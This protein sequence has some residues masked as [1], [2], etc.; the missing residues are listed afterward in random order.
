[1]IKWQQ[2]PPQRHIHGEMFLARQAMRDGDFNFA[3]GLI[4]PALSEG[5]GLTMDTYADLLFQMGDFPGAFKVWEELGDEDSLDY[6][7]KHVSVQNGREVEILALKSLYNIDPEKYTFLLIDRLRGQ[8]QTDQ[9]IS[10]LRSSIENF[11]DSKEQTN[12]FLT[13]GNIYQEKKLYDDAEVLYL[14]VLDENPENWQAWVGLGSSYFVNDKDYEKA[15]KCFQKAIAIEPTSSLAYQALGNLYASSEKWSDAIKAYQTAAELSPTD[16]SCQVSLAKAY[17]ASN[18][19]ANAINIYEN[20]VLQF[21][22]DA[23]FFYLLSEVYWLDKQPGEAITA[24][25]R[26]IQLDST[27]IS[28]LI[29]A[30]NYYEQQSLGEKA[31]TAYQAVIAIDPQNQVALAALARL[32]NSN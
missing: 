6:V 19:L 3:L 9:A 24:I 5:D 27:N 31:I 20:W 14:L 23:Y 26:S 1:M 10:I 30:G 32:E 25:E 16:R 7:I 15:L 21:P 2:A 12:W 17:I 28:A 13:L 4:E 18:Q 22:Q 29:T 8:Q 11:P